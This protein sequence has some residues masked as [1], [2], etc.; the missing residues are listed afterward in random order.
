MMGNNFVHS[1]THNSTR[2]VGHDI[3]ISGRLATNG[4]TLNI[5]VFDASNPDTIIATRLNVNVPRDFDTLAFRPTRTGTFY[6]QVRVGQTSTIDIIRVHVSATSLRQ[7][8]EILAFDHRAAGN[9]GYMYNLS[10][11]RTRYMDRIH[12]PFGNRWRSDLNP[13]HWE[14][15]DG[16][17]IVSRDSGILATNGAPIVSAT[18][19]R[20]T[21]SGFDASA[22]EFAVVLTNMTCPLTNR[23]L[24]VRYMHMQRGSAIAQGTLNLVPGVTPIG[25]TGNTGIGS[26]AHL[27]FEVH[28]HP[29]H[30]TLWFLNP[31]EY[32]HTYYINPQWLFPWINFVGSVS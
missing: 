13:P 27:H 2:P 10:A 6:I 4:G 11:A 9:W 23:A 31:S 8:Y 7:L 22:G 17:D 26:G 14:L 25:R 21:L 5:S 18:R 15:H 28:N 12:S 3:F 1:P 24:V 20:V 19:G 30:S 29:A 32:R 16:F